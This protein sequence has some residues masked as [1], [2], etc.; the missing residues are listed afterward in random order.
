M[1]NTR[2]TPRS[3]ALLMIAFLAASGCGQ[4]GGGSYGGQFCPDELHAGDSCD[5][6]G[7]NCSLGAD[8][9]GGGPVLTCNQDHQWVE[10]YDPRCCHD[11]DESQ[12]YPDCPA[13]LPTAGD[14]C[15]V[16]IGALPCTYTTDVGCGDG[17]A[18][19]ECDEDTKT[20]TVQL[21]QCGG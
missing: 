15:E 1:L 7:D 18:A 21:P 3:W 11:G 12:P 17:A 14:A 2:L 10:T 5:N 19:A 6:P 16:C 20:W 4:G 8:E 9:C 13:S